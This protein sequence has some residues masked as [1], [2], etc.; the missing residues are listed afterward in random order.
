MTIPEAS[1]RLLDSLPDFEPDIHFFPSGTKTAQDAAAAVGC[2]VAAIVKSLVFVVIFEDGKEEPVVAL[3][4]GDKRLDTKALAFAAGAA[5]S[6]RAA[7]DEARDATG[8]AA[9]G[10]P[11]FGHTRQLRVF[12]DPS[13]RRNDRVWAAGGTPTT[14][15]PISLEDLDRL[16]YPVWAEIAVR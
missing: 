5:S 2:P 8:Y 1:R 16:A 14:V 13:L 6:R 9:G 10:T 12:A 7:L 3:V 4:P 15:F 11:P